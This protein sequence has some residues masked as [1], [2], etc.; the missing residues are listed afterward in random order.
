MISMEL[1]GVQRNTETSALHNAAI[2]RFLAQGGTIHVVEGFVKRAEPAAKPYGRNT[3][4]PVPGDTVPAKRKA[5]PKPRT[6][7]SGVRVSEEV[8]ARVKHLA[9]TLPRIRIH[10]ETGLSGYV[11]NRIAE[12]GGF[13]FIR[14]NAND[15]TITRKPDPIA[16]AL[17]VVRIKD[18]RDRGL[19]QTAAFKDL[20]ISNTLLKRL[21]REF[22]IDYPSRQVC[23]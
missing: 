21:I 11:L 4:P 1:S 17:N 13:K 7:A 9:Q 6:G 2:E 22:A 12:E 23:P 19:S 20:Q 8:K 3:A 10:E 18:A 5:Q 14:L 15:I 16:D